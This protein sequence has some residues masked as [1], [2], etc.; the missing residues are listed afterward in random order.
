VL[1]EK[2][3]PADLSFP[4]RRRLNSV[5]RQDRRFPQVR[6][7]FAK[8]TTSVSIS[9]AVRG[10]PGNRFLLP[11]YFPAIRRRCQASS[12]SGV[13]IVPNS[14][15]TFRPSSFALTAN[16]RRWSSVKRVACRPPVPA[17]P[18]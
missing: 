1:L 11:S 8:R 18:D 12:V 9:F 7:S 16:R 17:A 10:R 6:F 15:S 3:L 5:A 2:F 14:I 13:T 4:L